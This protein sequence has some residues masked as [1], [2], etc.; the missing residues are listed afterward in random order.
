MFEKIFPPKKDEEGKRYNDGTKSGPDHQ[1]SAEDGDKETTAEKSDNDTGL[2]G[3]A[4]NGVVLT[5]EELKE[6]REN[7]DIHEQ[8]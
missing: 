8:P 2:V 4:P 7:R 3:A 6:W 1:V 5:P